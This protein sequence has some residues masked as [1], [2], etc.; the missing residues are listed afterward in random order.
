MEKTE[1]IIP[2]FGKA[3]DRR[4]IPATKVFN[5][6]SIMG[7]VLMDMN[8][9]RYS[10]TDSALRRY[11]IDFNKRIKLKPLPDL[12]LMMIYHPDDEKNLDA[13][14]SKIHI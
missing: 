12:R 14:I 1:Q 8:T 2:L 5:Q 3:G 6:V 4:R 9:Y 11:N 10:S 13:W 7:P